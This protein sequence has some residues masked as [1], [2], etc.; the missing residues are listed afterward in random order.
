MCTRLSPTHLAFRA[1]RDPIVVSALHC[2]C[3]NPGSNL[4]H[5]ILFT[6]SMTAFPQSSG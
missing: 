1:R 4:G 2:G 6:V 5:F 3:N